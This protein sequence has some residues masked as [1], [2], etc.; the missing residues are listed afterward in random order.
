MVCKTQVRYQT[1]THF[2]CFLATSFHTYSVSDFW[3]NLKCR[4]QLK[5]SSAELAAGTTIITS[6]FLYVCTENMY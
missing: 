2:P 1:V 5:L 6:L 3:S 4:S